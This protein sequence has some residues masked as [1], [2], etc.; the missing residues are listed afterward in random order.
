[1][2]KNNQK[3]F[4]YFV[5]GVALLALAGVGLI[6]FGGG[7]LFAVT[8]TQQIDQPGPPITALGT[9]ESS[10]DLTLTYNVFD[11]NPL[12]QSTSRN[13]DYNV[14]Y[15]FNGTFVG[16]TDSAGQISS[17]VPVNARVDL[18]FIDATEAGTTAYGFSDTIQMGCQNQAI[19]VPRGML[20]GGLT[21]T[22][23]DISTGLPTANAVGT[24]TAIGAGGTID[25]EWFNKVSTVNTRFGT[26]E[27]GAKALLVMDYN[28]LIEMPP[29][30]TELNAG[31]FEIS[32][33]PNGHT[34][35]AVVSSATSSIAYLITTDN[36]S[37]LR[38]L[39]IKGQIRTLTASSDPTGTDGNVGFTL[40]DSQM[41]QNDATLWV[42][43]FRDVNDGTDKGR[44][45]VTDEFHVT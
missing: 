35:T 31:T 39:S 20:T 32:T 37:Q 12:N 3:L 29:V 28:S 42:V 9:C 18:Y 13:A 30:I 23:Y 21:S 19:S 4:L 17:V 45:N 2:P 10:A 15:Y 44:A 34:S 38:S 36:L 14:H 5:G 41:Y 25:F 1:M 7:Q 11:E 16:I 24:P 27:G 26:T 33:V 22:M 40:Y 43:G 8:P 6:M